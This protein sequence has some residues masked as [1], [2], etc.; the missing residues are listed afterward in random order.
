MNDCYHPDTYTLKFMVGGQFL[1][2]EDTKFS[3]FAQLQGTLLSL[4]QTNDSRVVGL[5]QEF[6]VFAT[7]DYN[8]YRGK[9]YV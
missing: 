2:V 9:E 3:K 8:I 4:K 1:P 7:N 6:A 5:G